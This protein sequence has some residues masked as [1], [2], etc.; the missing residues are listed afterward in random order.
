[1]R[2]VLLVAERDYRQIL[3][4]R[5][6]WVM[7]LCVPLMIAASSVFGRVM[8]PPES[9]GY[10]LVDASGRYGAAVN[11]RL[12]LDYQRAVL[13][14]LSA[15]V[16]RW[17]LQAA[18]PGAVWTSGRR[19]VDDAEAQAFLASG[20]LPAALARIAPL[21]PK[22][23][24]PFK[25]PRRRAVRLD[26][27]ADVASNAGPDAFDRSVAPF[28]RSGITTPQGRRPLALAVYVPAGFG[29]PGAPV[30]M[31]TNGRPDEELIDAMRDELSHQLRL[32]A[33]AGAGLAPAAAER[34][35]ALSAP[36]LVK[37]PPQGGGSFEQA[38]TRSAL[39][40]AFTYLLLITAI[41]TGSMMLTAVMEERANKLLESV[42]ACVSPRELMYGKLLGLGAVG[43]TIIIA[44]AGFAAA[45][46]GSQQGVVADFLRPAL[47]SVAHPG[48]IAAL[49]FYF[50]AS[51]LVIST[52]FL[53]VGCLANTMQEAQ[54][55]LTPIIM[56]VLMPVMLMMGQVMRSPEATLAHTMSWIPIYTP[57]AMIA[58]LGGP[59]PAAEIAGTTMI[60]I[61]FIALELWA[62]GRLLEATVL[63]SGQPPKLA[64]AVRLILRPQG[65]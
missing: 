36:V 12:E 33:F 52:L 4:N 30:R 35:E 59:I 38:M 40:L 65:R 63:R 8:K 24:P 16:Q 31:W 2:R 39:P 28:L 41:T 23:A 1:M 6:F 50:L 34:L 54:A 46:A 55:Y 29:A 58:R 14:D 45:A 18:A 56:V 22:D 48:T 32:Q 17:K 9:I 64:A 37:A 43:L 61:G 21:K 15:Y 3:A 60:L 13:G 5:G 10:V 19:W 44:W 57:F 47:A 20:G 7:L 25:P 51:Y 62:L 53:G 49:V 26:P 27:P 11:Q 42:L